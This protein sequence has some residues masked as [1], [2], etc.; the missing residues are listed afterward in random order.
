MIKYLHL[1]P[2]LFTCNIIWQGYIL[3]PCIIIRQGCIFLSHHVLHCP[4]CIFKKVSYNCVEFLS[5]IIPVLWKLYITDNRRP[6]PPGS[7]YED[8]HHTAYACVLCYISLSGI[9]NHFPDTLQIMKHLIS[10]AAVRQPFDLVYM[11]DEVMPYYPH[12]R[13]KLRIILKL[14]AIILHII[15]KVMITLPQFPVF[16][17][18][19]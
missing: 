11:M 15:L 10:G 4:Q 5:P 17:P 14:P 13:L 9:L 7:G 18:H 3:P 16:H 2:W 8:I 19:P 12:I 1:Y 6:K